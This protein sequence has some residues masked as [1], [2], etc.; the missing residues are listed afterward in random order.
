[1]AVSFPVSLDDFTNPNSTDALNSPSHASQHSDNND[2]IE[3]LQSKVGI[4]SS[5]DAT[6]IDYKLT[7]SSSNNP[8]HK[9]T[10]AD[11]A[12]DVTA[13]VGEL[14]KL[15]GANA[16]TSDLNKLHDITASATD[17]N[18]IDGVT[19]GGTTSGDIVT[20]DG[21]QTLTNKTID[22]DNNTLQDINPESMKQSCGCHV[23]VTSNQTI[24]HSTITLVTFDNELYD[25]GGDFT[26]TAT[27]Y[28][29]TAP[30]A[31]YYLVAAQ[32][33]YVEAGAGSLI[34][35]Y[36]RLYK[37]GSLYQHAIGADD[38]NSDA[39][40]VPL[41][42][43]IYLAA[44]DYLQIY[45]RHFSGNNVVIEASGASFFTVTLLSK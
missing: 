3:A 17:I 5:A 30:V 26:N 14:N 15:S 2:A 36:I 28:K 13:T 38:A 42:T 44:S 9:H 37:N 27:N 41:V 16:T 12:S 29:F 18:Q 43:V 1:M 33:N 39:V 34:T 40:S 8:G 23:R 19:V 32:L 10:L 4:D 7:S 45:A 6:S 20:I 22:G 21:T 31:G 35:P 24:N 25:I 11:G